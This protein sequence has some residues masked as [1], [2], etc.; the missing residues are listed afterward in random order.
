MKIERFEDIRAWQEARKLVNEVFKLARDNK[1]LQRDFRFK[2]QMT[3]S[4]ISIMANIA[5]GFSRKY[6]KEFVQFLFIA[7]GSASELQSHLYVALDQNMISKDT[8]D[9][10][11]K[12]ADIAAR[13][14]SKFISYLSGRK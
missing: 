9:Q 3:S 12:Q 1:I 13:L 10:C 5:E 6:D 4:A 8:F 2:D 14:I 11:Y 7:K